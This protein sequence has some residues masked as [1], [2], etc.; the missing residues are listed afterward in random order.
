[1]R[2]AGRAR[3]IVRGRVQ[4]V[5]FRMETRREALGK[6]VTGWVSNR[7]DGSVEA[8]FEGKKADVEAML[9]WCRLGPSMARVDHVDVHW[10]E[11]AAPSHD[12]FQIR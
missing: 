2:A 11:G 5:F 3:V 1:M 10:E 6:N 7:P 4:G 8:L 12:T 9:E